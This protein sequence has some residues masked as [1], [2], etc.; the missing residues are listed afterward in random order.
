MRWCSLTSER[1]FSQTSNDTFFFF[2][3]NA[4][5]RSFARSQDSFKQ[6]T[7][8]QLALLN[9]SEVLSRFVKPNWKKK[10]L[11]NNS[12]IIYIGLG[13]KSFF[14]STG[15]W[16]SE[17]VSLWLSYEVWKTRREIRCTSNGLD[18]RVFG[19]SHLHYG[20][21]HHGDGPPLLASLREKL[22]IFN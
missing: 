20:E 14:L 4:L 15:G 17:A 19:W 18:D 2:F 10:Q 11:L 21:F 5:C 9:T 1:F 16:S 12:S 3:F 13:L 8:S 22:F 7:Q 6:E